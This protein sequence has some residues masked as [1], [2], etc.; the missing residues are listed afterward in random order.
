MADNKF[1]VP[2]FNHASLGIILT[3]DKGNITMANP[4]A[5]QLF[6]YELHELLNQKVEI[7]IPRR[8]THVEKRE[9]YGKNPVNRPMGMGVDLFGIKKNGL[10]FPVEVSLAHFKS[11]EGPNFIAFIND[12]TKRK[13]VEQELIDLNE[14]LEK[15]ILERTE[16]LK[17]AL[18]KEK[19]LSDLKSKF[20]SV[21]SHEFRTP[22]STVAS[23]TYLLSQY[24]KTEDQS[25]RDKHIQRII[26]SVNALNDILDDF[27]SESKIE[28]G[29][30]QILVGQFNLKEFV[31]E[32]LHDMVNHLKKGQKFNYKHTGSELIKSDKSAIKHIVQNLI[33]NAIKFSPEN[34]VID[35]FTSYKKGDI[36]IH[37]RDKGIGIPKKDQ[38]H[39][40]ERFYRAEN[41]S[42]IQGTGLG[43]HIAAKYI[44][45]LKGSIECTSEENVGTEFI[46]ELKE[47]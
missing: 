16:H 15:K 37:V 32:L 10:E 8:Y 36:Q 45:M 6:G 22:L 42:A 27:L 24:T 41:A 13:E 5:L 26:N 17:I 29:K 11:E 31:D 47:S 30:I 39:L 40:F 25:K 12:I 46:I 33:S 14:A 18:E 2:L 23:S 1:Y 44:E 35:I 43:L 7:L 4:F 19:A 34:A 28:E 3:N 21:A 9:A 20:V 38:E